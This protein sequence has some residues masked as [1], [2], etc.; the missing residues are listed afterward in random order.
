MTEVGKCAFL[1]SSYGE[2]IDPGNA[3]II[4]PEK[5]GSI[6]DYA[7]YGISA[8]YVMMNSWSREECVIGD[9]A[10]GNCSELRYFQVRT[11]GE[12][13]SFTIADKAFDGCSSELTFIGIENEQLK[14]FAVSHGFTYLENEMTW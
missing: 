10:F 1:D 8:S 9:Y 11:R 14:D 3:Y 5:T 12:D 6:E 4:I 2:T 13:V 7:F